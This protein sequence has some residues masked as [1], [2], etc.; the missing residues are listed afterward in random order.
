MKNTFIKR[1]HF[2]GFTEIG[3]IIFFILL[4]IFGYINS[5]N[6]S[7]EIQDLRNNK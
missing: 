1:E 4:V 7:K 5:K 3:V 2:M 6:I